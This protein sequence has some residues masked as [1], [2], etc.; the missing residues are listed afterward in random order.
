MSLPASI[1]SDLERYAAGP[2]LLRQAIAGLT[3]HQLRQPVPPGRWC[4]LQVLCHLA[5]FE[6]VYADRLK[7]VLAEEQPTLFG[8]DPDL[9]AARLD[10]LRRSPDEELAVIDAIRRQV[11][12]LLGERPAADFERTGIHSSDGPLSLAT[13]LA[14][15]ADHIPH[16]LKFIE[17]KRQAL[18]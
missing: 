7:R 2:A 6:I 16:H 13:L 15:I 4:I 5:D 17:Q 11:T 3:P 1:Q 14:R 8:G 10:Y 18:G 9:F 12:R